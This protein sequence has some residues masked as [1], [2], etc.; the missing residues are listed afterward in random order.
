MSDPV[1]NAEIEDVLSS[2]R[3]LV[4]EEVKPAPQAE[5]DASSQKRKE[6]VRS[7]LVL[8]PAFR[9]SSEDKP[10][11]DFAEKAPE[12]VTED[13]GAEV[14]EDRS[15]DNTEDETA[16]NQNPEDVSEDEQSEEMQSE[17]D[18]Q[19][20]TD[21]DTE[22]VDEALQETEA[23]QSEDHTQE[24]HA[25]DAA[26]EVEAEDAAEEVETEDDTEE[27]EPEAEQDSEDTAVAALVAEDNAEAQEEPETVEEWVDAEPDAAEVAFDRDALSA[28]EMTIAELEAAVGGQADE[29]EPDGSE[30]DEETPDEVPG[31]A[32]RLVN[33]TPEDAR[34]VKD[35]PAE[36]SE[37][38]EDSKVDATADETQF[39]EDDTLNEEA[40]IAE[41]EGFFDEEVSVI[42]EEALRDLVSEIVRQELQGSLGERITRNV[43][44]LVRREI[45]RAM[46]ARDFD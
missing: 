38:T 45:H 5:T 6:R 10:E 29:W 25:E 3:R 44:K 42:D 46:A 23:E 22:A 30:P 43:R 4:S 33:A 2:I 18:D 27:V 21:E 31:I 13:S 17:S 1:T 32:A 34:D 12:E 37:N 14:S 26:E 9:V 7:K 19:V 16:E 24:V 35:E 11:G 15:E 20:E 40:M 8:T 28:L 41:K 36:V 39:Y